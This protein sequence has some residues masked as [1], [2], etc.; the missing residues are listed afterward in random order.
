M[1]SY[2]VLV[3][4]FILTSCNKQKS[5]YQNNFE[6]VKDSLKTIYAPDTRVEVFDIKLVRKDK[7]SS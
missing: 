1:K 7:K 6:T 5:N 3:S 2:I 4:L